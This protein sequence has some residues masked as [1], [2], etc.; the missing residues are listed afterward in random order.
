MFFRQDVDA[1]SDAAEAEAHVAPNRTAYTPPTPE[2]MVKLRDWTPAAEWPGQ[3]HLTCPASLLPVALGTGFK[4]PHT[5][6]EAT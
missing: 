4:H 2:Q 3:F 5:C 1:C 6:P